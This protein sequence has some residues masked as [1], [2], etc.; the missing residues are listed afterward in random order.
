ML[1]VQE[2]PGQEVRYSGPGPWRW[3]IEKAQSPEEDEEQGPGPLQVG[4]QEAQRGKIRRKGDRR[5]PG[6]CVGPKEE[7]AWGT[8]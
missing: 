2:I 6:S 8:G 7:S 5:A 4:G 3:S 1:C